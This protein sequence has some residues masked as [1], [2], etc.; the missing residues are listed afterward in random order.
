MLCGGDYIF[1]FNMIF[2]THLKA[3]NDIA[4][5]ATKHFKIVSDICVCYS[6]WY[7]AAIVEK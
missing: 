3:L 7:S 1:L 6:T 2:M 4:A 5:C